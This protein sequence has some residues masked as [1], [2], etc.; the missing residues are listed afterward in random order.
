MEGLEQ[1][2]SRGFR[3]SSRRGDGTN[4]GIDDPRLI[5]ALALLGGGLFGA[6]LYL[7]LATQDPSL[8]V[9]ADIAGVGGVVCLA[10]ATLFAWSGSIGKGMVSRRL[11]R[12]LA[13]GGDEWVLDVGCGMGLLLVQSAKRLTTGQVVGIDVWGMHALADGGRY[14]ATRKNVTI[15]GVGGS[16]ELQQSDPK[17][18]PFV[19]GS[20]DVI[21]SASMLDR[22]RDLHRI[23]LAIGEMLRVLKPGGRIAI[24]TRSY[25]AE[26]GKVLQEK[27]MSD[28]T[29][30]ELHFQVF[31]P[32]RTISA[33]KK[34]TPPTSLQARP[35]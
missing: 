33:R 14:H 13:L 26:I 24:Q 19:D 31:P 17:S 18:L 5:L 27:G 32:S 2:V 11:L 30:S 12:T 3:A 15:E 28:V 34:F 29:I 9:I 20:F 6:S 23:D 35:H 1:S 16:I 7:G 22:S 4:Y 10:N 8:H 25:A 21:V